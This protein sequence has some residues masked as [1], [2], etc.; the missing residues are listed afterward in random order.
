[1]LAFLA[2]IP[3]SFLEVHLMTVSSSPSKLAMMNLSASLPVPLQYDAL[4]AEAFVGMTL[5]IIATISVMVLNLYRRAV[6][7]RMA[8]W[9]GSL[10]RLLKPLMS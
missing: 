5:W 1:M 6:A 7:R 4:A 3:L 8:G 9:V 10:S 2:T